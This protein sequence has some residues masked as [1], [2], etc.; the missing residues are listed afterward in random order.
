MAV[1]HVGVLQVRDLRGG[2]GGSGCV[3]GEVLGVSVQK[4]SDADVLAIHRRLVGGERQGVV[5]RE[6]GV[7]TR[8]VRLRL[9]AAGLDGGR[10]GRPKLAPMSHCRTCRCKAQAGDGGAA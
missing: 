8:A 10:R 1:V 6:Y 7:T 2:A 5:A 4:L 3:V 9:H